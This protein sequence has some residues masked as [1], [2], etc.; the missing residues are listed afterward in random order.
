MDRN[1]EKESFQQPVVDREGGRESSPEHISMPI[2]MVRTLGSGMDHQDCRGKK[3][4]P[5]EGGPL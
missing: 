4:T 3:A 1:A 2:A 5:K